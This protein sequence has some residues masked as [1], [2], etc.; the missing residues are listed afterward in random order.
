MYFL[1]PHH[2]MKIQF[3]Y[4]IVQHHLV[5]RKT[6]FSGREERKRI[7]PPWPLT[8]AVGPIAN[9]P[10]S[11]WANFTICAIVLPKF[12]VESQEKKTTQLRERLL[13]L[14][15]IVFQITSHT[16]VFL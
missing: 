16:G 12:Q 7:Q 8:R 14:E 3:H 10:R 9:L 15:A 1:A 11:L 2:I 13:I 6:I 5:F 4:I